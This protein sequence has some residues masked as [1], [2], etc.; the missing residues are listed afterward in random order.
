MDAD[1]PVMLWQTWMTNRASESAQQTTSVCQK[2]KK[3]KNV[4]LER[5]SS[6]I[7]T[8]KHVLLLFSHSGDG[9][10]VL[11]YVSLCVSPII[12]WFLTYS[13]TLK[14]WIWVY[15]TLRCSIQHETSLMQGLNQSN[16]VFTYSHDNL[17]ELLGIRTH[18]P[19]EHS[20]LKKKK[21]RKSVQP[22]SVMFPSVSTSLN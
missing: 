22:D 1:S 2:Q 15:V 11:L 4:A 17:I 18:N 16:P 9:S 20:R 14:C 13:L 7:F 19:T 6:F 8:C 3:K 21:E 10:G 5:Y 12:V